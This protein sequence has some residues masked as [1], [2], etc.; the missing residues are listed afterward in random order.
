MQ[1]TAGD[2]QRECLDSLIT[3]GDADFPAA[4]RQGIVGMDA[5]V[6]GGDGK[7]AAADRQIP[8]GV[9]GVVG[10]VEGK[11]TAGDLQS[12]AGLQPFALGVSSAV[13]ICCPPH[14]PQPGRISPLRSVLA[15]ALPPPAF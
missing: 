10:G 9:Y 1:G 12:A 7:Y 8:V 5:V 14:A 13:W 3:A 2:L 11:L 4:D 15:L 6:A